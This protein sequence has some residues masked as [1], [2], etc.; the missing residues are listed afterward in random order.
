MTPSTSHTPR[1]SLQ[2]LRVALVYPPYGTIRNEPGLAVV[3]ENYGVIPNLSLLYVAGVL[4]SVGCEVLFIDAFAERLDIPSTLARLRAF[5][6]SFIG[7]TLTTYLF[8][9]TLEWIEAIRRE[10]D[11]PV[12]V[13]GVHLSLYPR[14]TLLRDAIDYGVTGEAESILPELLDA[15]VQG[16]PLDGIAGIAF[17]RGAPGPQGRDVQ[18]TAPAPLADPDLSPLPARHLIDNSRYYSFISQY[19]NFTP[20]MTSRGCPFRCVFCE[21]GGRRWRG[22]SPENVASEIEL[23]VREHGVR[24]LDFF[25]SAFTIRK[26]RVL[27]ICQEIHRRKLDIV[28]TARS[29]IDSVDP[30]MLRAMRAAGCVRIYYGIESGNREILRTLKK[31]TDLDRIREVV[32]TTKALDIRTFGYFM[33]GSPGEDRAT[34]RQSIRL[35]I[36]LDLDYAQFSKVTPMP[37]TEL[38]E[39]LM[40]ESGRDWWREILL[41]GNEIQIPRPSCHLSDQEVEEATREAYLRFYFRPTYAIRA[42]LRMK[43]GAEL[44]RSIKTALAMLRARSSAD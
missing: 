16:R 13:G 29:R 30:E 3:K 22:R 21:Q 18:V 40:T 32:R 38:Y 11:V 42:I 26:D 2:G 4:E 31:L 6:P 36:E 7:Y 1:P 17:K 41:E 15:L 37:G 20:I 9:Q 5:S 35:A 33:V 12:I 19:K 23:A 39:L 28:W 44:E 10:F 43:S 24:E 25:D 34:V 14:E 8:F 27:G